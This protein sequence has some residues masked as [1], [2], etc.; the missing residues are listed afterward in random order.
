MTQRAW[1]NLLRGCSLASIAS[2]L[3]VLGFVLLTDPALPQESV[4]VHGSNATTQIAAGASAGLKGEE[5]LRLAQRPLRREINDKPAAPPPALALKL[6]GTVVEPGRSRAIL[7]GADGKAQ[8]RGIGDIV[9]G[10]EVLE[11][12]ADSITVRYL[13]SPMVLKP[14]KEGR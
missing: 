12:A 4:R 3:A 5:L 11:I 8:L 6:S 2:A 7:I 10:A 14:N 13:G 1:R 9:D